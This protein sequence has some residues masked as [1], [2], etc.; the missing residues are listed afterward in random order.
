M[1]IGREGVERGSEP[2][3]S[4]AG[5]GRSRCVP[6]IG[7][8]FSFGAYELRAKRVGD[9]RCATT[10]WSSSIGSGGGAKTTLRGAKGFL[11]T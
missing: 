3:S 9:S 10:A 1:W 6:L 7:V 2:A 5:E 11:G 8:M 4:G